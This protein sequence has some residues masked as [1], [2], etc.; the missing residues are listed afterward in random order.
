MATRESPTCR[1]AILDPLLRFDG[2]GG[3][4]SQQSEDDT[5]P[6]HMASPLSLV[7]EYQSTE[8]GY[9][10]QCCVSRANFQERFLLVGHFWLRELEGSTHRST[11][12][13]NE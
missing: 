12:Q 2:G 7:D 11:H 3:P 4:S 6:I 9:S 10:H 8:D 1:F 13:A 5:Q